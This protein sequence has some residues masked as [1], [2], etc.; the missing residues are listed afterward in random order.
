VEVDVFRA[1]WEIECC[2]P[3]PGEGDRVT[4]PLLWVDDPSGPG[5]LL[6]SH[7]SLDAW[8]VGLSPG[9]VPGRGRLLADLHGGL[10][11]AAL[12][13]T[14]ASVVSVRVVE[15]AYRLAMPGGYEPIAGGYVLRPVS[16]SPRWFG[17]GPSEDGPWP[18]VL[19]RDSGV[20]VGLRGD[21]PGDMLPG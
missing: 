14:P 6:L 18:G 17:G 12:L 8:W 10:P 7:G 1:G 11:D 4:W 5:G 21:G 19:R 15:Q 9:A 3:A 2:R 20:L 13:P 16:R